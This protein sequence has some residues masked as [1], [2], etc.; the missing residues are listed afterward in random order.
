LTRRPDFSFRAKFI[1][2]P[3]KRGRR[4]RSPGCPTAAAPLACL[5]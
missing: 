5:P 1:R 4:A 3:Q 2:L